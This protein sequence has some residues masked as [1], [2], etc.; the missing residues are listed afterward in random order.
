MFDMNM[1]WEK[2]IYVSLRKYIPNGFTITDKTSKN[3]WQPDNGNR[4]SKLRPD[5]V[6]KNR[7]KNT[8]EN[9]DKI[10]V[11]DTKWKNLGNHNPSPDDLRQLYVYSKYYNAKR[12]ALVYPGVENFIKKGTY[13]SE[14]SDQLGE[15][16]CSV[17]S[18]SVN[19]N[20]KQWQVDIKKQII[21]NWM[22][23]KRDD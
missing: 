12:V 8:K 13:Y 2:F 19:K 23:K 16:E 4:N 6:I 20:I 21:D 22:E 7:N 10:F 14:N 11:I 18:I 3:F 1:L 9:K 5:I 17:I 15:E